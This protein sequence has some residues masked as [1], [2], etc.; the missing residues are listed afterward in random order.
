MIGR[1]ERKHRS[2]TIFSILVVLIMMIPLLIENEVKANIKIEENSELNTQL[3]S[4]WIKHFG[5]TTRGHVVIQTSDGGYLVA[6]GT[7]WYFD[8]EALLIKTDG[9]GNKQWD[10]TVGEPTEWDYFDGIIETS[11][12]GFLVSGTKDFKGSLIKVD[13]DGNILWEKI[14]GGLT[15][16]SC[17]DVIQTQDG[18][19]IMVARLYSEPERGWLI[20]TDSE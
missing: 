10:L 7:A 16:G 1:E 9:E 6:G 4:G 17:I 5:G 19:F 2:K 8:S 15:N 3:G 13:V 12:D 20:K 11:D 18:N 14:Y